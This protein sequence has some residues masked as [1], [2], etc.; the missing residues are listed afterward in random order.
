MS[1]YRLDRLVAPRSI[2]VVGGSPRERSLG[3]AVLCNLRAAGFP[4]S[5]HLVNPRHDHIDGVPAVKKLEALP[6]VP[7]IVVV[8]A[9]AAAV[10]DIIAEAGA[11]GTAAAVVISAGLGHGLDSLAE[12]ARRRARAHGIRLL[13][14]NGL[15]I[16]VPRAKLNASFAAHMPGAGDLTVISQS[17]AI[18]AGLAEWATHRNVGFAAL[19]SIGDAVDVDFGDLLDFFA[20][21]HGTRA[22]LLYVE[23]ISDAR[24]FMSA[25]RIAAR[26]KPVIILKSGRHAQGARAAATHTGA[27]A[28]VDAVYG[29]AFFRAGLLR[30]WDLDELFAAA[31]TL[32]R[33]PRVSGKRLAVLTNGGG[34]GVLA[35]DRLIDLGGCLAALSPA[36]SQR[37]DA[38]LPPAWSKA[39]PV[40]IVGDADAAR[41]AVALEALIA[42][43]EN[44]AVL[45]LNV[46]TALA[47]ASDSARA[48][49]DVVN[50]ARSREHQPK[51]V[52]AVWVGAEPG[53]AARFAA[54]SIPHYEDEA[55]ALR[56]FMHLVRYREAGEAL[57]ETPPSLPADFIP[58]AEQARAVVGK[59]LG[60]RLSWLDPFDTCRLLQ[61]YDI[62]TLPVAFG[63]DPDHAAAAAAPLLAQGAA[64]VVKIVSPDIV[65]KSEVGGVKLNLTSTAAVR[66]AAAEILARAKALKPEA[67]IAG[68]AVYPMIVRPRARELIVGIA[69]DLTFG[70]VV[71]FG[72]GGTAVEIVKDKALALP[73]LDLKLARDLIA[74]TE[75]S[76]VLKAY[77]NVPAADEHAL[78]LTL[79]K[80]A[81]LAADVPEIR[82]LDLN[83]VLADE[84]GVIAVDARVAINALEPR[85]RGLRGHPRFAIRPY[86][87]EW[88]RHIALSGGTHVLVRPVRPED[89]DR[90]REFATHVSPEDVRLRFFAPIREITHAFLARLTQIDYA[91]AMAFVAID[92]RSKAMLGV[93]RLHVDA[94]YEAGEFAILVRSDLK[95]QGLGWQLMQL[96]IEYAR[97]E[98]LRRI[99]GQVLDEN[100]TMLAMC[101]ELG[102]KV[103]SDRQSPGVS[104]VQLAIGS[105]AGE[106]SR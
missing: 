25:A 4:G 49:I 65:H 39:N 31:E 83:P 100:A 98:G 40:D 91:R 44:D 14:P 69:D 88:E 81:Q 85:P 77:R 95:G 29:A 33:L 13:G 104:L 73:P 11:L 74:R 41:Y 6:H 19:V 76:R 38:A 96:I 7:D 10:P 94:N 24:K 48:V 15:G 20:L 21:D 27:L 89:E 62:P 1:T 17:G 50:K 72:Q 18:T 35:V 16:I 67:R 32:G 9:P 64:V 59:A 47:S 103:S 75:V 34:I 52:L 54:A 61:A 63:L 93:V 66:E 22:I 5:L 84:H 105:P 57:M 101:R 82:E 45:V 43:P 12:A 86:P 8:T 2:A 68:V 102:F 97:A 87:K 56:G 3:R 71:V 51:P 53:V 99:E 92:A 79:V 36:T 37:L 30:V 46:P 106:Q 42:D 78:A 28:G 70:P 60:E 26:T 90:F 80:I 55:D 58:D 23:S